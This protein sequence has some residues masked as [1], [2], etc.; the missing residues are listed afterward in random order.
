MQITAQDQVAVGLNEKLCLA[1][2]ANYQLRISCTIV[3]AQS[4]LGFDKANSI[5]MTN[6][7]PRLLSVLY[8][9]YRLRM[10]YLR[11]AGGCPRASG[12]A[13]AN[14]SGPFLDAPRH[15]VADVFTRAQG[16]HQS[17][18]S[19]GRKHHPLH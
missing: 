16:G 13:P 6:C 9:I 12:L 14:G 3:F 7:V 15:W 8:A 18:A 19:N 1:D 17:T 5:D 2:I 4:L 10:G 11:L